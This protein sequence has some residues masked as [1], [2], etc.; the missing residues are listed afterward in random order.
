MYFK[1]DFKI[2]DGMVAYKMQLAHVFYLINQ[3]G[4]NQSF[5]NKYGSMFLIFLTNNKRN[6][7]V[8]HYLGKNLQTFITF[9]ILIKFT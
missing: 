8:D 3:N 4:I 2:N 6:F 7:I 1:V 9:A 5:P